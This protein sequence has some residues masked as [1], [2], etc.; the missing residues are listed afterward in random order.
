MKVACLQ[1]DVI[2]GDVEKNIELVEV[3]LKEA[4]LGKPDIVVLPEL[5][6]TGYDLQRL[7][8]LAD[9]NGKAMQ[10]VFS[11]WAK[12][13]AVTIVGGSI[14]K[15]IGTDV[16]NTMY[17]YNKQGE[18]LM[19]YSKAHL[20]QL[21]DEH[22][23]LTAGST[24]GI[25]SIEDT[26]CAGFIC[27]DIRFPEWMRTHTVAGAEILFVVAEWPLPRLAHWETLLRARAIENQCYVVACNR[28][29]A[30]PNNVFAGNSLVIDPWGEIVAR[31]GQEAGILYGELHRERVK[32]V[33]KGI[34]V[35]A[36]RRKNI[37]Q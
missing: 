25:F 17:V 16:T 14:A 24:T 35:F 32:E 21:M 26:L 10:A 28:A 5:W 13:F 31:L 29:G 9:E 7:N 19:E 20:F 8:V 12:Q 37:Y 36:D 22:K 4:M 1:T 3:M 27:Y 23:Y 33:R 34:P 2:F 15:R 30:D 11:K 6:S 18:C